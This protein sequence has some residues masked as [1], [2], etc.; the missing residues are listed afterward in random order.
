MAGH[1][2]S[3]VPD[4]RTQ[5]RGAGG[6]GIKADQID[7]HCEEEIFIVF[8]CDISV[9][10]FPPLLIMLLLFYSK[11]IVHIMGARRVSN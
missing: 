2:N 9:L 4:G 11:G 8:F 5:F 10:P 7:K 1:D 6:E 3:R